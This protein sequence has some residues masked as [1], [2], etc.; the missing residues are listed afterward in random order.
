MTRL[1]VLEVRQSLDM[2]IAH[3]DG[4]DDHKIQGHYEH[5]C[6]LRELVIHEQYSKGKQFKLDTFFKCRTTPILRPGL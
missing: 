3:V 6:S 5:L 1:K 2:F 4:T